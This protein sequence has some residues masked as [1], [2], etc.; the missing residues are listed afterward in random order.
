[1]KKSDFK[2]M[3]RKMVREEVAMAIQEVITELKQPTQ[4]VSKPKPK[5]KMVE[6]KSYTSNSILN[7]M[8][9]ETANDEWQTMGN[10]TYTSNKMNDVLRGQYGDMMNGGNVNVAPQTDI[11]DRPVTNVP[12][13]LMDAF[14]KD[15]SKTL[16]AMEKSAN[17]SRGV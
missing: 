4:Q 10:G 13:H 11:N 3:I 7:D 12:D 9:N 14:T 16:K 8:L 6:K 17:K 5:K 2:L 1:M 15:Y